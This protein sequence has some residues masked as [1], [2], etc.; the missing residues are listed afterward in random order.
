VRRGLYAH[1]AGIRTKKSYGFVGNTVHQLDQL[2]Y[3][4]FTNAQ[5]RTLYVTDPPIEILDWA[6]A[7][8]Q[9]L[10]VRPPFQVPYFLLA[11]GAKAGD[12]LKKLGWRH[13]PLTS[14]RLDNLIT[15]MDVDY[16]LA[17]D[18]A[19]NG[20]YGIQDAIDITIDWLAQG[21]L[22]AQKAE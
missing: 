2:M 14:F 20:P 13:P 4:D 3:R 21:H 17:G 9:S 15:D 10:N 5:G 8:A 16:M 18:V 6:N 19:G 12:I 7:I 22:T 11:A 1:P